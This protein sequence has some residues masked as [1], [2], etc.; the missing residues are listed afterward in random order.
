MLFLYLKNLNSP[1]CTGK[2]SYEVI[3]HIRQNTQANGSITSEVT[4]VTVTTSAY[5][6]NAQ[7][8]NVY[9]EPQI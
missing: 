3:V 9:F 1:K 7:D 6:F 5:K 2:E 8:Y 4:G